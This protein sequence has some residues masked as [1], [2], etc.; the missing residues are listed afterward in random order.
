M[1][2]SALFAGLILLVAGDVMAGAEWPSFQPNL[3]PGETMSPNAATLPADVEVAPPGA[4]VPADLAKLSGT[5]TGWMCRDRACSTRLAVERLTATGGTIVYAF[6]NQRQQ[7]AVS[8]IE[9][10]WADGE[11]SG[12]LADGPTVTYRLRPDGHLD[13]L[14]FSSLDQWASGLLVRDP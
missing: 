5:W 1:R 7:N 8:R 12:R 3:K 2:I 4:D 6:A 13:V 10:T 11:L 14:W 9:A